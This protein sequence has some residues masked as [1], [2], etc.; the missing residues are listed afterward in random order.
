MRDDLKLLLEIQKLDDEISD[1]RDL[2]EDLSDGLE[3]SRSVVE[4]AKV[5]LKGAAEEL[6][7]L[8]KSV[9]MKNLG[10]KEKEDAMEKDRDNMIRITSNKEYKAVLSQMEKDKTDLSLIEDALLE[11]MGRVDEVAAELSKEEDLV[12]EKGAALT[13]E[14]AEAARQIAAS[15]ARVDSLQEKKSSIAA[16][17][18][19]ELMESYG[20]IAARRDGQVVVSLANNMCGGCHMTLTS[21]TFSELLKGDNIIHCMTCGRMLYIE[22]EQSEE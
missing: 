10:I 5:R 2:Q 17:V 12:A 11:E 9:D 6:L 15:S 13:A 14:E 16:G 3:E 19:P 1:E 18:A 8:K 22:D 4:E 21:Q 7:E 20:K